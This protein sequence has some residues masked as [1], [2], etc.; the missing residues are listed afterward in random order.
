MATFLFQMALINCLLLIAMSTSTALPIPAIEAVPVVAA[1]S[2]YHTSAENHDDV[3]TEFSSKPNFTNK[4]Y[5][6]ELQIKFA[7]K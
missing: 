4:L 5:Y 1:Y 3:L 7:L 2:R 6:V